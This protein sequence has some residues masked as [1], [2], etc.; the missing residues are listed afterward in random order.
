MLLTVFTKA[1]CQSR[2]TSFFVS[3]ADTCSFHKDLR[4]TNHAL[5]AWALVAI[6]LPTGVWGSV[7]ETAP[8]RHVVAGGYGPEE[9]ASGRVWKRP[10][11]L[12]QGQV[13]AT[14]LSGPASRQ[15]DPSEHLLG[16]YR[17][18][19]IVLRPLYAPSSSP[20]RTAHCPGNITTP[21]MDEKTEI[22][23]V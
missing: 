5:S 16:I 1:P 17:M 19:G 9:E 13:L 15:M 10:W 22:P 8:S 4:A 3:E 7:S 20:L 21:F 18:P 2:L 12:S 6:G 14:R 23:G 11:S